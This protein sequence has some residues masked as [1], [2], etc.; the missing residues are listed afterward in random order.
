MT[1]TGKEACITGCDAGARAPGTRDSARANAVP[2]KVDWT[3]TP[4][5]PQPGLRRAQAVRGARQLRPL[6]E[7]QVTREIHRLKDRHRVSR[8]LRRDEGR[9]IPACYFRNNAARYSGVDEAIMPFLATPA[10]SC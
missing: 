2:A 10:W 6:R 8:R 7:G 9:V 5:W 1:A 3:K 4:E